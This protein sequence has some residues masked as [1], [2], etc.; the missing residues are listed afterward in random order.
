M[1]ETIDIL[2]FS[3]LERITREPG[4]SMDVFSEKIAQ[5]KNYS[6]LCP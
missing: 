1:L 4:T 3:R 6:F 5:L 2:E